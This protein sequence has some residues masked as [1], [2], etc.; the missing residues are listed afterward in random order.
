MKRFIQ[1][2]LLCLVLIVSVFAIAADTLVTPVAT[3]TSTPVTEAC[4]FQGLALITDGTN[5][6]TLNIYD[7]TGVTTTRLIPTNSTILGTD[8]RFG[9]KPPFP[10]RCSTGVHVTIAVAGGGTCAYQVFYSRVR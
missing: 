8:Y 7:G 1:T 6:V 4:W 10:V 5:N 2:S 9:Y 3:A